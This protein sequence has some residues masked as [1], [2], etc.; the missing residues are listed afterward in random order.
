MGP[1]MRTERFDELVVSRVIT[2]L[3]D[4]MLDTVITGWVPVTTNLSSN[5]LKQ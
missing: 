1:W 4:P 2:R 3:A 5:P